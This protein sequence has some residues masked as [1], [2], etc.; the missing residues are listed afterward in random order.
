MSNPK[1]G[2]TLVELSIVI[3]IIG[4][5]AAVAWPYYQGHI[6]RARLTEVENAMSVVG[7]SV[8]SYYQYSEGAW[9]DC[10]SINEIRNTLGVGLVSITRISQINIVNGV[11]T[12]TVDNID[13]MVNNKTLILTPSV[14][15]DG[16]IRWVWG[17]S[18]DF[19]MHL[20]PKS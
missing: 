11:I 1:S 16:S 17:S 9:P 2:F 8:S 12:A 19:P 7:S 4:I 18:A 6:I 13:P 20:R 14:T 3:C 5:L 10:P 15:G